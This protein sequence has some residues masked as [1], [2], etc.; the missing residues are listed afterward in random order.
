MTQSRVAG[1]APTVVPLGL[2]HI[3]IRVRDQA[4]SQRFYRD[5]LGC[6]VERVNPETS[7][8]QMRCGE[9]IIDLVPGEGA[10]LPEDKRGLVHFCISVACEDL[11]ALASTLK[12]RGIAVD[13]TPKPRTGAY[14]RN[15]SFY[16]RDPDGYHIELKPRV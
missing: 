13:N 4:A 6:T 3:V 2:D 11:E 10:C 14:G 12:A 7:L 16:I 9:H 8:L 15:P 5:V 1:A